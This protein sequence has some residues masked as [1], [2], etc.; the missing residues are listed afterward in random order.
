MSLPRKSPLQKA[1]SARP[2]YCNNPSHFLV[3]AIREVNL[4]CQVMK[5]EKKKALKWN[6]RIGGTDYSSTNNNSCFDWR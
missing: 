2:L 3:L 5:K 1:A 6:N 4:S